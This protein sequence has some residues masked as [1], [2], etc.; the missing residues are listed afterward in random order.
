MP[1]AIF[2]AG[3]PKKINRETGREDCKLVRQR[4]ATHPAACSS[5]VHD[6]SQAEA[7]WVAEWLAWEPAETSQTSAGLCIPVDPRPPYLVQDL[8]TQLNDPHGHLIN[9]K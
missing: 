5:F 1:S 7:P 9:W 8:L 3:F 2:P 6:G 4:G